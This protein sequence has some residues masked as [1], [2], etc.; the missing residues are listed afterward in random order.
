[1]KRDKRGARQ[2][3]SVSL[4]EGAAC[5]LSA[6]KTEAETACLR[7]Q[8]PSGRHWGRRPLMKRSGIS[9]SCAGIDLKSVSYRTSD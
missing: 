6:L 3:W 7:Y 8:R 1:M 5:A 4:N 2:A 9:K